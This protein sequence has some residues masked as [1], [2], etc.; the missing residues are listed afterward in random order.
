MHR[1]RSTTTSG[2][3]S[4]V[5]TRVSDSTRVGVESLFVMT[6]LDSSQLGQKTRLEPEV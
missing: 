1:L 3:G 2:L 6:R 5:M 4:V